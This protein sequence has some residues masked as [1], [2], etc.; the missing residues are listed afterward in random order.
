M[1]FYFINHFL[2]PRFGTPIWGRT[3][4][5]GDPNLWM[6]FY[7]IFLKFGA[8]IGKLLKKKINTNENNSLF[9]FKKYDE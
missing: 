2:G 1:N 5:F 8:K 6:N 3:I 7:L 4:R 9:E